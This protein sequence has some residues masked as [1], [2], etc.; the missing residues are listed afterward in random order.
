MLS[1]GFSDS[2]LREDCSECIGTRLNW[3]WMTFEDL[4]LTSSRDDVFE[5]DL[6]EVLRIWTRHHLGMMS[7]R[8][9]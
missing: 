3:F 1:L 9:I 7:S 6:S 8:P 5:T 4:D 2:I